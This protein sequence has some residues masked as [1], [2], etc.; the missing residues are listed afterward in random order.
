MSVL[1]SVLP[2]TGPSVPRSWDGSRSPRSIAR[3]AALK[4]PGRPSGLTQTR[5]LLS[6]L[7]AGRSRVVRAASR[8]RPGSGICESLRPVAARCSQRALLPPVRNVVP[9]SGAGARFVGGP[10]AHASPLLSLESAGAPRFSLPLPLQCRAW[11]L[12]LCGCLFGLVALLSLWKVCP[13]LHHPPVRSSNVTRRSVF[14]RPNG[15][16]GAGVSRR[17]AEDL[18]R[19]RPQ[20]NLPCGKQAP[21]RTDGGTPCERDVKAAI[22]STD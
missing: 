20:V 4:A 7:E 1:L 2:V 3:L 19:R 14:L 5:G 10:F 21:A 17:P 22:Q 15:H 12:V 18:L 9:C 11:L 16:R 13:P 6:R 8:P